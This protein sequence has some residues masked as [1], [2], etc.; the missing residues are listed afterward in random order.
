MQSASY[1]H[2][3][4]TAKNEK[5]L[6]ILWLLKKLNWID[7]SGGVQQVKYLEFK[8]THKLTAP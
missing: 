1:R 8:N 2:S 4:L 5:L 6:L 3:V 7:N